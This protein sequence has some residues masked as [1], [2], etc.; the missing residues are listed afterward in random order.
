MHRPELIRGRDEQHARQIDVD[1]EIVVAERWFCAGSSTS[2]SAAAG[3][4]WN[5]AEILSISSSMNTGFIAPACFN[6]CTIRPGMAP[7]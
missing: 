3:S 2:S 4:P 7:M 1:L 6:A 5:P